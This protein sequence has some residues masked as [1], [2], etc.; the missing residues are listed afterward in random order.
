[1]NLGRVVALSSAG[2]LV[3]IFV[4][5]GC[6]T[7]AASHVK[8]VDGSTNPSLEVVNRHATCPFI[9]TAVATGALPYQFEQG[10]PLASVDDVV[11]L[12]DTGGGDLGSR[13]LVIFATGNHA[14]MLSGNDLTK[15]DTPVPH[16]LFSLDFPG[17]QG[18][19]P[20]HS[21]IL[22]GDPTELNSGRFDAV[23]FARLIALANNGHIKRSDFGKFIAGNLRRDPNSKVFSLHT[24]GLLGRDL[25]TFVA[26]T[27]PALLA[28]LQSIATGSSANDEVRQLV[29]SLT[30]L[31]GEDNLV[32]SAGEFGL[33]FAFLA[34]SPKTTI[35]DGEPALSTDDVT[36]M[37]RD[38][39]F[40]D[41][42]SQW[43][44]TSHAWVINTIGL[45]KSAA[46]EY[47]HPTDS[48][49]SEPTVTTVANHVGGLSS[50]FDY[51]CG[52]LAKSLFGYYSVLPE[53]QTN[54]SANW[55]SVSAADGYQ[56]GIYA[57]GSND[58]NKVICLMGTF[59]YDRK[60]FKYIAE[61][62]KSECPAGLL[63]YGE[64]GCQ[65]PD[66]VSRTLSE[67]NQ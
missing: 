62:R 20:G 56:R 1:M 33:L 6:K 5:V 42:W 26:S 22:Q 53:G 54:K 29:I 21:G 44:K 4:L 14:L 51:F 11:S 8:E 65:T 31:A 27:G 50:G 36:L 13:V 47:L 60:S 45:A 43:K 10:G 15:L 63:F 59:S 24:A 25:A 67:L 61:S 28:H 39:R 49:D 12:G 35:V 2:L 7:S 34:N 38:K 16:G 41:G 52:T 48:E 30:K 9:G 66:D 40:P 17:S 3:P 19:H 18:S 64:S 55:I 58:I 46:S 23:A 57:I 37:F 32:G